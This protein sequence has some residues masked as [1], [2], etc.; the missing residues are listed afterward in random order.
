MATKQ[1]LYEITFAVLAIVAVGIALLDI[2]GSIDLMTNL[3]LY[4]LDL[5]ITIIFAVDYF[6]RLIRA[7]KKTEFIR[8]N[9]PDLIAIIPFSSLFKAFRLLKLVRLLKLLKLARI[10]ALSSRFKDS[11]KRFLKTNGLYYVLIFTVSMILIGSA[12]IYFFERDITID[13]FSDAIWWSFVTATTV[14]YG[15]ISPATTAGRIVA[16]CL[17]LIG[18]GTIGM[19]TGSI[20]T[21]FIGGHNEPEQPPVIDTVQALQQYHQLLLDGAITEAD[22]EKIK[23]K[24]LGE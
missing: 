17:M 22:Y 1:T 6:V 20:A 15:D 19:L 4:Y 12:L 23:N 11:I 9:I 2:A 18:I 14:G 24:L 13:S 5:A 21:F 3:F 8:K 10:V 16:S 7:D